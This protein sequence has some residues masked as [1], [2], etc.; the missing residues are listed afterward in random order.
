MMKTFFDNL[1]VHEWA[2]VPV[3][4]LTFSQQM[5]EYCKANACGN[6]NKSW[7]CPP[8]CG[9]IEEQK[10]KI[11]SYKEALVFTSK[12]NI[13]DSFDY[14]GMEKGRQQHTL[15]T[16]DVSNKLLRKIDD[17]LVYSAGQCPVCTKCMFPDSCAFPKKRI[18]S[19]EA[20][21]IDAAELSKVCNIAY[22]NGNNTVTFFSIIV[23]SALTL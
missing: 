15:L 16:L 17:I 2:I 23:S 3:T 13:E 12:Y 9:S 10:K 5:L 4:K 18:G 1:A 20:A 19:I 6:Y 14:E 7:T 11:L 22:N 8:A 21:G